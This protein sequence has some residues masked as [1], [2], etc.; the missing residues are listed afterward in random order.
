MMILDINKCIFIITLIL[1]TVNPRVLAE[2][3]ASCNYTNKE[4]NGGQ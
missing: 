3:V 1:K 2:G 4:M